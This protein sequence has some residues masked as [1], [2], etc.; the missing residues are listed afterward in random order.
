MIPLIMTTTAYDPRIAH[1]FGTHVSDLI[2]DL[3]A[4]I[5]KH[6]GNARGRSMIASASTKADMEIADTSS[7]E[8]VAAYIRYL[9]A[10]I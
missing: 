8:W 7:H 10:C 1:R 5:R 4:K 2:P 6:Y 3:E 9:K